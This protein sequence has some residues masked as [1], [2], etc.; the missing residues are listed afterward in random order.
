M[1]FLVLFIGICWVCVIVRGV[2][3]KMIISIG[4][5]ILIRG[6]E[7]LKFNGLF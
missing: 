1:I 4:N 3:I 5:L 7:D 6:R 2:L